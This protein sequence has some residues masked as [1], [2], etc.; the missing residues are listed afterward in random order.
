MA[1]LISFSILTISLIGIV[2]A[3]GVCRASR[4]AD[5]TFSALRFEKMDELLDG[6][7]G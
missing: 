5:E 6:E 2:L 7:R 4:Q 1:V 3:L